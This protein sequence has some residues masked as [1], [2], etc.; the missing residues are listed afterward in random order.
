M[1]T[2][3]A[4]LELSIDNDGRTT[5][6]LIGEID[7]SNAAGIEQQLVHVTQHINALTLDLTGLDYLDSQGVAIIQR[8]A[9]R[10]T[11]GDLLLSILAAP[12]SIVNDVL[13]ITHIAHSLRAA[14]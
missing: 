11:N 10:H 14:N 13:T 5:A 8:L 2:P 1:T 12:D 9:D 6:S 7:L 3:L 4:R